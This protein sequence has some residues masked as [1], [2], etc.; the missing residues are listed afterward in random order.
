MLIISFDNQL[1]LPAHSH[2]VLISKAPQVF[3]RQV[4]Y[5][6]SV[7]PPHR[8]VSRGRNSGQVIA[9]SPKK[10]KRLNSARERCLNTQTELATPP[11]MV[12]WLVRE[13]CLFLHRIQGFSEFRRHFRTLCSRIPQNMA[14]IVRLR[15]LLALKSPFTQ[16]DGLHD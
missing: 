2:L 4:R 11:E 1:S 10:S 7:S 8:V 5:L 16:F 12:S 6:S 15:F 3:P 13:V 9:N 14:F